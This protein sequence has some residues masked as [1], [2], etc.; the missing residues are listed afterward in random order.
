MLTSIKVLHYLCCVFPKTEFKQVIEIL[1]SE[2]FQG[3]LWNYKENN[4][5]K[6]IPGSSYKS[7]KTK[8]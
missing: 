2:C 6:D 4:H 1:M 5:E 7:W 3:K 8:C